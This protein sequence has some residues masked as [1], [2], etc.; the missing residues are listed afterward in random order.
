MLI[1]DG[2]VAEQSPPLLTRNGKHQLPEEF[3]TS[4]KNSV[5]D[6][7]LTD[8]KNVFDR[9]DF[10]PRI[11][12]GSFASEGEFPFLAHGVTDDD[13]CGGTLI[14]PDVV[15]T[16]A[17]CQGAYSNDVIIGSNDLF[18]RD[19]AE[20]IGI[21]FLYPHPDYS[22]WTEENDIMLI[23]L[24]SPSTGPL[25]TLNKDPNLPTD[26]QA[27][28]VMG[29]GRTSETG[30]VSPKLLKVEVEAIGFDTCSAQLPG[31]VF[32]ESYLCAGVTAGRK[33]ACEGDT[34]GALL[35]S[36]T[37]VQ[38]GVLASFGIGC[39]REASPGMYT[40]VSF[41]SDW[42]QDFVCNN[43]SM[44]TNDCDSLPPGKTDA[45]SGAPTDPPSSQGPSPTLGQQVPPSLSPSEHSEP[46]RRPSPSA[47]SSSEKSSSKSSK[48]VSKSKFK[49]SQKSS[50]SSISDSVK[51]GKGKGTGTGKGKGKGKEK[52]DKKM[53]K[54]RQKNRKKRANSSVN[55][56]IR[57]KKRANTPGNRAI[58]RKRRQQRRNGTD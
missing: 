7:S 41:Y 28:T 15:L 6:R 19:M 31:L 38:Y 11:A 27:V 23:K 46:T 44:P 4:L 2:P 14:H 34:G 20:R 32:E 35:D 37:F 30:P 39:G 18:G 33:G 48:S 29:F 12:G 17:R 1:L 24:V 16:A 49:N 57:R 40:R 43:S 47:L 8:V 51:S 5:T 36:G 21:D 50:S 9:T 53:N 55:K 3:A 25:V 22:P 13:L 54:R 56:A 26:G 45:P 52:D 42:I 10:Q 58:R